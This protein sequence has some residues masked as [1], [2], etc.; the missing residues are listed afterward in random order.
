[1]T[2]HYWLVVHPDIKSP[3]GG[4]K[5]MHRLAEAIVSVG[6]QATI[7]QDMASFH[8]GWFTSSVNTISHESWIAKRDSILSPHSDILIFPET[9]IQSIRDYSRGLPSV[10]FNQNASYS[11]GVP[12]S[13]AFIQPQKLSILYR[14][15]N[16]KHVLCVSWYDYDFLS[17]YVLCNDT[18]ISCIVNGLEDSIFQPIGPKTRQIVYMP[19]KNVLD[20]FIVSGLIDS[21]AL[22]RT[23]SVLPIHNQSHDQVLQAFRS[24]FLFLSFGH[25]EGFGL[26]VAEALSSACAVVGYSGL[27]GRELFEIGSRF[28]MAEEIPFGDWG[29]FV[30]AVEHF[31]LSLRQDSQK[32]LSSL[33]SLSNEMYSRYSLQSMRKSVSSVLDLIEAK[34]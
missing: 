3:V 28:S 12:G 20:S 5:Q 16:I 17:R 31:E 34:I 27:G 4:V 21:S 30:N 25:P 1:M 23:W 29:A 24:S 6:R 13:N 15:S 18:K 10:I 26:P 22:L 32:V 7:I 8:P 33:S 9:Y 14:Q 2:L 19:R 11:F